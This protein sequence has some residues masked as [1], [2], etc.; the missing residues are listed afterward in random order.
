MSL[1]QAAGNRPMRSDIF[2][3]HRPLHAAGRRPF[4]A[5]LI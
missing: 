1:E 5:R 3:W 4:A 2:I